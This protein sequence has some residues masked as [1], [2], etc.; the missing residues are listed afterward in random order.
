MHVEMRGSETRMSVFWQTVVFV[1]FIGTLGREYP[2]KC[3]A[4]MISVNLW[5]LSTV[6]HDW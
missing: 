1:L 6:T 4:Q 2:A 3:Q 5:I